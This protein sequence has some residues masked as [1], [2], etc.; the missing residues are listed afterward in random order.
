MK[1]TIAG[2]L[3][4]VLACSVLSAQQP[5]AAAPGSPI[6]GAFVHDTV[7]SIR[8]LIQ[9]KYFD[10]SAIPGIEAAL[11]AAEQRGAYAGA[12]DL[13]DLSARLNKTLDQA[14]HD[15]H[16]FVS[17]SELPAAT[18]TEPALPRAERA[19]LDNYGMKRAEI[20]DGNVGYLQITAFYRANEGAET[21]QAAM[22]FVAHTDALILDLRNNGGGSSDTA[23][24]LLS[25]FFNDPGRLLLSII[26]RSGE[27][28]IFNAQATGVAYRDESRPLYV[29]VSGSTWSAGEAVPFIL[30]E[31]RR[32]TI[33]GQKTAGAANPA[34]PWP[35]NSSLTMT[36]PFGR[37][38]SAVK[39]SNWDGVGVIPE[40]EASPDKALAV[41][42]KDAL[43]RLMNSTTDAARKKLLSRAVSAAGARK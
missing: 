13:K 38:K 5:S 3:V 33:V 14:S 8:A 19:R 17:P 11:T 32:A 2:V 20:L 15:K 30:Q 41:A 12:T 9:E 39:G 34:G 28:Q 25:Y 35:I 21:L 10:T 26:G 1:R 23:I 7:A 24:Q 4:L 27:P 42:Y 22:N 40:I 6:D 29:L 31:Q 18:S 36:I 43:D 16:L 37:I